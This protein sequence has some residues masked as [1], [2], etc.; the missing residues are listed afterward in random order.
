MNIPT[1]LQHDPTAR[2]PVGTI[3]AGVTIALPLQEVSHDDGQ[4][5]DQEEWRAFVRYAQPQMLE[6]LRQHVGGVQPATEP[7]FSLDG[8]HSDPIQGTLYVMTAAA[9][10]N[11]YAL[12][13]DCQ[14]YRAHHAPEHRRG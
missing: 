6:K 1:E 13:V 7:Q 9:W 5:W 14:A 8:P 10:V 3:L 4:P 11:P 12:P 2:G